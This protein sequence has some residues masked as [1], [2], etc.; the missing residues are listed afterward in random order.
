MVQDLNLVKLTAC[1]HPYNCITMPILD[2]SILVTEWSF[3]DKK[4]TSW[5]VAV[6]LLILI[7]RHEPVEKLQELL[8]AGK[9]AEFVFLT[10]DDTHHSKKCPQRREM[11][12]T[13][14]H[15]LF[16]KSPELSSYNYNIWY[17]AIG[18]LVQPPK[19]DKGSYAIPL[20]MEM[21]GPRFYIVSSVLKTLGTTA[22][23]D[24][25][26]HR[27]R[28]QLS[29]RFRSVPHT[30]HE[31]ITKMWPKLHEMA[32]PY[33]HWLTQQPILARDELPLVGGC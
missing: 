25:G 18:D 10:Y 11:G 17:S 23:D 26:S 27:L 19:T 21:L 4:N 29:L 16:R 1:Y 31:F 13:L 12:R 7:M 22:C 2:D 30:P 5:Q 14:W 32:A 20:L 3:H 6:E 24:C 28:M 8:K 15:E 9:P 33:D